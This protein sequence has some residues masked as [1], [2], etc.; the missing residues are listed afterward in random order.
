M[1]AVKPIV[2]LVDYT[3]NP[4]NLIAD[5]ARLCYADDEK[6]KS[7]F[8]GNIDSVDDARMIR[9]LAKNRHLSPFGHAK[10]TFELEGI[11]RTL[12]PQLVRHRMASYSQRSQR[13]VAHADFDFIIPTSIED[14]GRSDEFSKDMKVIGDMYGKWRG[15]LTEEAGLT[16]ENNNQDARYVLPNACETKIGVTMNAGELLKSFF[17][18]RLCNRAQWEIR[19]VAK[20]MLELAYPTAP[21]IFKY[22]GPSC[23]TEDKCY[24]GKKTCGRRNETVDYFTNLNK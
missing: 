23:Y 20:E 7:L 5:M 9:V 24:Q 4:E 1:G 2:K 6:V 21:N 3:S 22:A 16:G 10:W 8:Q 14:I 15:I 12:T 19:G 17:H 13:Y 18:E 11:S